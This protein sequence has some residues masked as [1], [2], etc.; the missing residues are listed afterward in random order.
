MISIAQ[1]L[2]RTVERITIWGSGL[3]LLLDGWLVAGKATVDIK[4]KILI[5]LGIAIFAA[6]TILI[7]RTLHRR[8]EGVAQVIRKINYVQLGHQPGAYLEGE[9]LLPQHWEKFGTPRWREPIFSLSYVC[10]PIVA[11]F[12]LAVIWTL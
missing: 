7:I 11:A 9:A 4:G 3:V 6:I 8:Y 10:I 5:S 2:R 12:G 1:E